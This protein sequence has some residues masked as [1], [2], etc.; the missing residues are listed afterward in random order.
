MTRH[1][2]II[3]LCMILG[4]CAQDPNSSQSARATMAAP[5][6][7][8]LSSV[9]ALFI[10]DSF[11]T[12]S[13][14]APRV[15]LTAAHCLVGATAAQVS[16]TLQADITDFTH[17]T[18]V[19]AA[20]LHVHP[21]FKDWSETSGD[22]AHAGHADI[23]IVILK[24]TEYGGAPKSPYPVAPDEGFTKGTGIF[25]AGFGF[26]KGGSYGKL[27][28]KEMTFDRYE[29]GKD[30]AGKAIGHEL[31]T[32]VPGPTNELLCGGDSGAP[33]FSSING[34]ITIIAVHSFGYDTSSANDSPGVQCQKTT[35]DAFVN[36][37]TYQT[38]ISSF[39]K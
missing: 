6:A 14:I 22:D 2:V 35:V 17:A 4:A 30:T 11:C 24:G 31:L 10:K 27:R 39:L 18:G 38:W 29:D 15:V 32:V 1:L 21:D 12:G 37:A 33:L 20:S 13:L 5:T 9:G 8:D 16:F 19:G 7:T 25:G 28:A 3:T 36:V 34:K 26:D 23:G